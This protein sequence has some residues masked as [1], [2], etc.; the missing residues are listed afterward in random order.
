MDRLGNCYRSFSGKGKGMG[1]GDSSG[2]R[3]TLPSS[4]DNNEGPSLGLSGL[5]GE[6]EKQPLPLLEGG[7]R[8]RASWIMTSRR[9]DLNCRRCFQAG[10]SAECSRATSSWGWPGRP[11]VPGSHHGLDLSHN[12]LIEN[13][14][15]PGDPTSDLCKKQKAAPIT[16][17]CVDRVSLVLNNA[18][19]APY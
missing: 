2:A 15:L 11:W 5:V 8:P 4:R 12:T 16:R 10:Q 17:Q 3:N 14:P 7:A 1:E 18:A 9:K 6:M 19:R 13:P